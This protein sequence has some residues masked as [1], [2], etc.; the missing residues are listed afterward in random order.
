MSADENNRSTVTGSTRLKAHHMSTPRV[1]VGTYAKYNNGRI[2][3]QWLDLEDYSDREEF[4]AACAELHS[5]ES[6]PEY[7]FQ[8]HEGFPEG[9]VGESYISD[10]AFE[11][12]ALSED[13]RELFKV[14]RAHID[15]TGTIDQAREAYRGQ[16]ES[17]AAYV[18]ETVEETNV[19][20]EFL[21][22]Y[23]NW[24]DMAYDWE[25]N[26]HVFVEMAHDDVWVF[27]PR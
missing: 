9:T 2:A 26:D 1:Y 27:L 22:A 16:Y 20:P 18:Q 25:K 6:D 12:A 11:F 19:I 10:E 23:I 15:Q 8:D 17:A 14:Y 7:M 24:K 3:G 4:L 13:D 21:A 5:D